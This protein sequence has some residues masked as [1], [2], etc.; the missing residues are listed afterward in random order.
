MGG[1]VP[2][3]YR[4]QDRKLM[5]NEPEARFIRNLF[6]RYLELKSVPKLARE[7]R[8]RSAAMARTP[9]GPESM[10]SLGAGAYHL[11]GE[12]SRRDVDAYNGRGDTDHSDD[13]HREGS[14]GQRDEPDEFQ[15]EIDLYGSISELS[16]RLDRYRLRPVSLGLVYRL[17]AN[18]LY[19]GKARHKDEVYDGEH[20]A[21]VDADLFDAVQKQLPWELPFRR[22]RPHIGTCISSLASCSTTPATG[23]RQHT[24]RQEAGVIDT[25]S[26]AG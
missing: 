17:L 19:V 26:P 14:V 5:I 2:L 22:E 11:G 25:M 3:G 1:T 9:A 10:A 16:P 6:N 7:M 12:T 8:R 13:P 15:A 23:C 21:I 18:P 4:V 20:Q 24:P